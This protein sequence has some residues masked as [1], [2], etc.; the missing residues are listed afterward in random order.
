MT[1]KVSCR[2]VESVPLRGLR[3]GFSNS[4]VPECGSC[5]FGG[6]GV[7]RQEQADSIARLLDAASARIS[8]SNMRAG[9]MI[10]CY[11]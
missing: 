2:V 10:D 4:G 5:T 3:H 1:R 11:A 7:G 6:Y 8:L 9:R